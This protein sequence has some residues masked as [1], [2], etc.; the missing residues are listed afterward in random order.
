M[1]ESPASGRKIG[2]CKPFDDGWLLSG[3]AAQRLFDKS[4]I[5]KPMPENDLLLL[6]SEIL[7]C[8][9]HRHLQLT[10]EWLENELS[11]NGELLHETAAMEALR[12]P[13][14]KIVISQN[15]PEISP[16]SIVSDGTWALR[17]ERSSKVK[18]DLPTAEVV[19]VREF[20]PIDWSSLYQ[21]ASEVNTIGR[22][23]EILIV[24]E[25]MGVTTYRVSPENPRGALAPLDESILLEMDDFLLGNKWD[26]AFIPSSIDLPEQIG[27]PIPEG[28]WIDEDEVRIF[29][30]AHD[31]EGSIG[32][33]RDVISRKLLPRS[34]FKYGTKW[35]LYELSVGEDHAP[36]LLQPEWLAPRDWAQACLAARLAN[37]VHKTWLCG[38]NNEG[39]WRY[40]AIHRPP[41]EARWSGFRHQKHI[42]SID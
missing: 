42:P 29:E 27:S 1:A 9:R 22:I 5:G 16:D 21:W 39:S 40:I 24:D 17:W 4:A 7:F 15:V 3:P 19:W 28:T 2:P 20:E 23:A 34:G 6:P 14:E 12:V 18:T 36:W 31:D 25:E 38:F 30:D 33:L 41:P 8:A 10:D 35:R 37:G 11:N 26:G 32:L 13:G